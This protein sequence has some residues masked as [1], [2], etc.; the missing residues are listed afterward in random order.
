MLIGQNCFFNIN[1]K[2]N[3]SEMNLS[4]V[5]LKQV[6]FWSDSRTQ[7][8]CAKPFHDD[9]SETRCWWRWLIHGRL[10]EADGAQERG[11]RALAWKLERQTLMTFNWKKM[12]IGWLKKWADQLLDQRNEETMNELI[13]IEVELIVRCPWRR[14]QLISP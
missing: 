12:A 13:A 8:E 7:W 11:K 5:F 4:N 3:K 2:F 10:P 9:T 6:F 14:Q 1:F